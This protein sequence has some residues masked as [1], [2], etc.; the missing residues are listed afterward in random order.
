MSVII[1]ERKHFTNGVSVSID[2]DINE[3]DLSGAR[4]QVKFDTKIVGGVGSKFTIRHSNSSHQAV[5]DYTSSLMESSTEGTSHVFIVDLTDEILQH[6]K[7]FTVTTNGSLGTDAVHLEVT[8]VEIRTLEHIQI[9]YDLFALKTYQMVKKGET[10]ETSDTSNG[11]LLITSGQAKPLTAKMGKVLL[12]SDT[13]KVFYYDG[14]EWR[15]H[16]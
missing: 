7:F 15:E 11:V 4:I 10:S 6:S 13:G 2:Y 3:L 12:E 1:D 14:A 5:G 8:N 16:V 9:N